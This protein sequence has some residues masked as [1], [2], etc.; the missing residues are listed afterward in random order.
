MNQYQTTSPDYSMVPNPLYAKYVQMGGALLFFVIWFWLGLGLVVL[1][2]VG[3][4]IAW[5]SQNSMMKVIEGSLYPGT[6]L[7]VFVTITS[8]IYMIIKFIAYSRINSRKGTFITLLIVCEALNICSN[9]IVAIVSIILGS[10]FSYN[11]PRQTIIST[12]INC[13]I[14][15]YFVLS[16]RVRT[17]LGSD[18][19]ITDVFFAKLFKLKPP[20][21][22]EPYLVSYHPNPY[23]QGQTVP[24]QQQAPYSSNQLQTPPTPPDPST[25]I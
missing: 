4:L 17:Y 25:R 19:Y 11:V 23:Q 1:S 22:V 13:L 3:I 24:C 8:I 5:L 9:I 7:L 18:K 20:I 6:F 10:G 2:T 12:V 21:P 15:T 16:V 14:I